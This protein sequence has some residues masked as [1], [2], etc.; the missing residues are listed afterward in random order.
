MATHIDGMD[1]TVIGGGL[2]GSEAA[3]QAAE[4]GLQ[5]RLYEMRPIKNTGAHTSSNLAELVCSNSLGSTLFDRP[6]GLLKNELRTLNSMLLECAEATALPAGTALAVD[7]AGFANMVTQ[8]IIEHPRI[9]S[10]TGGGARDSRGIDDH[11]IRTIDFRVPGEIH[12]ESYWRGL[13]VLF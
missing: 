4:R 6:S 10:D 5:V 13:L 12:F 8:R 1:L 9:K 3:W 2:A 7:R 11:C